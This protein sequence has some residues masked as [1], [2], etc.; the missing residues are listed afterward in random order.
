MNSE[1]QAEFVRKRAETHRQNTANLQSDPLIRYMLDAHKST[2]LIK[3]PM[4]R[5]F[6]RRHQAE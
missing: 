5:G 1:A 3:T 6:L 2:T 4:R